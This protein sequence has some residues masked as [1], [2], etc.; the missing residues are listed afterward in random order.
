MSTL[1]PPANVQ[2]FPNDPQKQSALVQ[3]WTNFLDAFMQIAILGD[4]WTNVNDE[5][6]VLFFNPLATPVSPSAIVA[7]ITWIAFPNRLSSYFATSQGSP[8]ALGDVDMYQ[9]S[10][11]GYLKQNPA[12]ANGFPSVPTDIYPSINWKQPKEDREPFGPP[13]P[14]GWQDEYCEWCVERNADG[15]IVSVT[16]TC[17]NPE[18]WVALWKTD[19]TAVL[20]IYQNVIDASIRL[21]DLYL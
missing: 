20:A 9:L 1:L 19:P 4:P 21:E 5:N 14:R 17:E 10:D 6:R 11:Q 8:F 15:K 18:Y 3:R 2:D 16:F 12:F 7:P 13:G